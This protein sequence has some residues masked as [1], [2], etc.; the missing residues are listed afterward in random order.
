[1]TESIKWLYFN[2]HDLVRVRVEDGHPS[3][4]AVRFVFEPF[5]TDFLEHIDL[6]MQFE[7]PE[8]GEYSF[9]SDS[10]LFT[11]KVVYMNRYKLYLAKDDSVITLAGKRDLVQFV[12]PVLQWLMLRR[13]HCLIHSAAIAVK[14][15]GILLPGWGGTGKTSSIVCLLKEIPGASFLSDDFT[16]LS[17]EGNLLAYPKAFFI[18]PYHRNLF[19][20]LFKQ[21]H[22]PLV[23]P[24]LSNVLEHV[25]TVVRPICMAF[26]KLENIARRIT[27]EH[28]QIPARTALPDVEF[29]GSAPLDTVLFMERYSGTQTQIIEISVEEA[30]RRLV[31]NWYYEQQRCGQDAFLAA[32]STAL[33][34]ISEFFAKMASVI[35]SAF[36][37][38]KIFLLRTAKLRPKE[39]GKV[40]V[41]KVCKVL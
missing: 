14:G 18:Y 2:I 1:M 5:Q 17:A 28:M 12:G 33:F 24:V 38:R 23:P 30:R 20:H 21:K 19:P 13:Q 36:S 8:M 29:S 25:R 32:G 15:R 41:E 16:I 34:D 11:D 40:V 27:P 10:Y 39:F 6:S 3:E 37:N 31:G 4:Y 35:E 9:A 26:P 22:K 7:P